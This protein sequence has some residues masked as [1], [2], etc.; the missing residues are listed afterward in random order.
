MNY[1]ELHWV[2]YLIGIMICPRL[3]IAIAATIYG[4]LLGLPIIILVVLWLMTI[5]LKEKK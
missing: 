5:S 1:H 2:W 3:T 4:S